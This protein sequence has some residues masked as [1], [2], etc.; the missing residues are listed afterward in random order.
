[1]VDHHSHE[2][3][4]DDPRI[5]LSHNASS[6]PLFYVIAKERVDLRNK[7]TKE[8]L[9]E[10]VSLKCRIQQQPKEPLIA[11]VFLQC[12]ISHGVKDRKIVFIPHRGKQSLVT[13]P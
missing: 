4:D 13:L 6:L 5:D 2:C 8:S 9:C 3:P 1:M 11:L 7:V 10:I 12:P